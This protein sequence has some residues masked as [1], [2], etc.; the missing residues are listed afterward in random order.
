MA[1][2]HKAVITYKQRAISEILED[3]ALVSAINSHVASAD[4]IVYRNIYPFF[5]VPTAD[6]ETTTYLTICIDYPET[7]HPENNIRQIA[8]KICIIVH[9]DLMETDYGA[10]RLDYIAERCDNIFLDSLKY[11]FGR[12]RL[13]SSSETSLTQFHRCRELIYVSNESQGT[14]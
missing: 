10:T 9:Q 2:L 7:Y 11:G 3:E 13:L 6:T 8:L 1:N 4:E 14:C 5:R 12:L